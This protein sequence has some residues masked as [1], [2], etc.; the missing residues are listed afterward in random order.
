MKKE[1]HAKQLEGLQE[2]DSLCL[3][4]WE[5]NFSELSKWKQRLD[6][7]VMFGPRKSEFV[8]IISQ[9]LS[10]LTAHTKSPNFVCRS[11]LDRS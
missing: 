8:N 3:L 11:I 1:L 9:M 4:I 2:Q 7:S 5:L 6:F 10:S